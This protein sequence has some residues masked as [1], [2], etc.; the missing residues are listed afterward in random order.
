ML[1]SGRLLTAGSQLC[2]NGRWMALMMAQ[3][4][5]HQT[6]A[7]YLEYQSD[8]VQQTAQRGQTARTLGFLASGLSG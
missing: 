6:L 3:P 2:S 7:T 8:S 1:S 4:Q 5:G